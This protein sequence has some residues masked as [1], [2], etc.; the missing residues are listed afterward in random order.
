MFTKDCTR[1]ADCSKSSLRCEEQTSG[2]RCTHD[3]CYGDLCNLGGNS[4]ADGIGRLA[5]ILSLLL[6]I[7]FTFVEFQCF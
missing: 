3:C 4:K 5:S 6:A 1:H 2:E 7:K